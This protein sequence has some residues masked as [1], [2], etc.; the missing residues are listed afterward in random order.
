[1]RRA[2]RSTP[3]VPPVLWEDLRSLARALLAHPVARREAL[4]RRILCGARRARRYG[5]LTGR[6]HPCWGNGSVDAAARVFPLAVEPFPG[7]GDYAACLSL[8]LAALSGR[9]AA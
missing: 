6:C 7:D 4:C 1:M 2:Q 9:G 8:A 3:P 5:Q